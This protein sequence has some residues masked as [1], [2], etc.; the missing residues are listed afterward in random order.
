MIEEQ[1][2]QARREFD[3]VKDAWSARE[4]VTG[5][6]IGFKM[7]G[8][9]QTRQLAIRVYVRQKLPPEQ[10]PPRERIPEEVGGVPV[11]VIEGTFTAR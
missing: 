10:V 4:S 11:D 6:D 5:M 3:R 1:F 7:V 2:E 8:G 9:Q